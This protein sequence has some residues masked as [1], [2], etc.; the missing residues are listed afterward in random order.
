MGG[1]DYPEHQRAPSP[2]RVFLQHL[3]D[4]DAEGLVIEALVDEVF[5]NPELGGGHRLAL[6]DPRQV[7][8]ELFVMPP[9][10][11]ELLIVLHCQGETEKSI[12]VQFLEEDGGL[13]GL[14]R[15]VAEPHA[16]AKGIKRLARRKT[17]G[18]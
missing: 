4:A 6:W 14:F 15:E 16:C 7:K 2:V 11:Q 12:S 17:Q 9:H 13:Q 1:G 18:V 5:I 3:V 8:S 10:R